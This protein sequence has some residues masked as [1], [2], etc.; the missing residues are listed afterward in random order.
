MNQRHTTRTKF[1]AIAVLLLALLAG[2]ASA[3][4]NSTFEATP[5]ST[6]WTVVGAPVVTPG[7]TPGS[8]QGARFTAVGQSLAQSVTWGAEWQLDNYFAI[9]SSAAAR[10]YSLIIGIGG[11]NGINLRYGEGGGFAVF[12]GQTSAWVA[13]PALGTISASVDGNSDGDFLDAG[14]VKNTYRIRIIGHAF[15]TAGWNYEIY[16]SEAN[17]TEFT[18]SVGGLTTY[19]NVT[20]ASA[21]PTSITYGTVNGSNPGF[22][23]DEVKSHDELPAPSTIRHFLTDAGNIGGAGLP[24]SAVLSWVVENAD[25]VTIS[26][27]GPVANSGTTAVTPGTATTYTLTATRNGVAAAATATLTIAVGA[28]TLAPVINEFQAA[29]GTLQDED[30][31]RPD[32]VELR[33]PNAFTLNLAGYSLSDTAA[34]GDDWTFPLSNIPPNGYLVVF[35]S[36]KNRAVVGSPLHTHFSLNGSGEYLALHAPGG[37]LVQQFHADYPATLKFPRQFDRSTYGL[38]G[39]GAAKFFKPGTPGAANGTAYDG[40]VEDTVFSIKRGIFTTAQSVAIT[41]ATPGAQIRYTTTSAEP[42]ATTGTV[43]S[44][45]L[46]ISTTTTLRAAAFKTSFAPTNIDTNT[47]IFPATVVSQP[48]MSTVITSD[49]TY[50]PQMVAALTDLPSISVV[51][52]STIVNGS[53]AL[54]SFEY[55]PTTG[56]GVHENAGVELFGGAFTNFAKKS[57]RLKFKAEYGGTKV[58]IPGVFASHAHGWK[59]VE[60]FDS[61]ELRSGSHDMKVRGF[62]MANRFTDGLMFEMGQFATH[63]RFVHLYLN[64]TYWG[65]YHLRERWDANHHTAYFGGPGDD[66]ETI[67]GNLNVGGWADPGDAYDGDGSSWTR[68]KSL[69]SD[70]TGTQRLGRR[71][72]P[73]LASSSL[74]TTRPT[75]CWAA[76]SAGSSPV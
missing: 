61:L 36:Q 7:I 26:G 64:G 40:V 39:T 31:D 29:D 5:F 57:Y 12:N 56:V 63:G 43:Y 30:G 60:S 13:L 67:N 42:T 6:G 65:M 25:A 66:H 21:F 17:S 51:T 2:R 59:P 27:I 4:T 38:D 8:V 76:W 1:A 45:P 32:W 54:C 10:T 48:T 74:T 55:I 73:F 72:K 53:E 44:G 58:T 14:D 24:S 33:N 16:V 52:P 18:R 37:A 22:W 75:P 62:T 49:P 71:T 23:L 28:T 34:P 19:Q 35:A 11:N 41:T 46:T 50:G 15:G 70:Y 69:R 68:I 3:L 9:R 47:Y 20:G